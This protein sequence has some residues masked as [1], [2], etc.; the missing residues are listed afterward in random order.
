MRKKQKNRL[1]I[2]IIIPELS[3]Y[4]GAERVVIECVTRWQH[5]HDLTIY[6]ANFNIDILKEHGVTKNVELVKISPNFEGPH[7]MLLNCVLL[8]KIWEHEIGLHDVY[9]THLWPTH[10]IDL[11]PSVWYP[12]EP[13]RILHDLKFNQSV[14]FTSGKAVRNIHIYPKYNYDTVSDI[15]V[16]SYLKSMD[17]FDKLGKPDRIVA[18]SRYSA[19]YLEDV[20]NRK[21]KDIVYPGVNDKD[22]FYIPSTENIILTVGQLWPHKRM[23]LIIEAIK[24]VEEIQLYI[25]GSGPDID[26]LSLAAKKLGVSDRVF[27][28]SGLTN[29]EVQILFSR[30]MAVVF[31]P[32]KEP[33]GIVALEAMAAGKP[34]IGVNEG[35]YV[36]IVDDSCAFLVPPQPIAIA[37]KIRNLKDNKDVAIKMGQAGLKRAKKYN[38]DRTAG[39][40]ITIIEDTHREWKRKHKP[41]RRLKERTL[42]G[43]QYYC[44][45]GDGLGS[46]HWND[47]PTFG[48]VT[49]MSLLGYYSSSHGDIIMEHFRLLEEAGVDFL[50]LNLH[51]DGDGINGYELACIEN[52]FSIA[53]STGT[54]LRLALQLCIY[55]GKRKDIVTLLK[56]IEKVF[57][58]RSNY[59]KL[60]GKPV[61]SFFWTGAYDGNK[62][63]MTMLD[64]YTEDFVRISSSLRM[65]PPKTEYK[66]TFG[67]F[68][69]FSLFSPLEMCAPDNWEKLWAES[70]KESKSGSMDM[71]IAALSPGYDDSHLKDPNRK[72]NPY[73]TIHREGINTYKRMIDFTLSRG[74]RPHM[75]I[76]S[77][78]NEYHENT[79]IEPSAEHESLYMDMT[80]DFIKKAKAK[81]KK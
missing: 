6:A 9:H 40:L 61:L 54:K 29:L 47:N 63:F 80:R 78:F 72:N 49:D 53:K 43:V 70:Y 62:N 58:K 15:M 64:N 52:I 20:Y 46:A 81:W 67:F 14:E 12:H 31:T 4:G 8:P 66:K 21:V 56:L 41:P 74:K 42:F 30:C 79:H 5:L 60:Q 22:F 32:I 16:D 34:L 77:T 55:D 2:G 26:K 19:K 48:G 11:H 28:L 23:K 57:A 39:E 10:L 68:D 45:Y 44:W 65:Y 73:R 37:E 69:G 13:L 51:V 36:E 25:V 24:Y 33:F 27:F 35:G 76:F 3:K 17:S 18:N 1:D 59:L 71:R 7:S 75:V 38:W 50:L